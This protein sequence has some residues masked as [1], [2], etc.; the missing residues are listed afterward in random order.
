VTKPAPTETDGRQSLLKTLGSGVLTSIPVLSALVFIVVSLKVFRVSGMETTTTVA[1]VSKADT[2]ALLRGVIVTILP[3]FLE[4]LTA[5]TLWAWGAALPSRAQN[6]QAD[7]RAALY[8]PEAAAAWIMTVIMFFTIA[9]PVFLLFFAPVALT[10]FA[11]SRAIRHPEAVPW[12]LRLRKTLLVV[13]LCV[14]T[15]S[16]GL[17]TLASNPW[18][19]LQ[20][21]TVAPNHILT[22]NNRQLP[23]TFAAYVLN[24]DSQTVTLLLDQPRAVIEVTRG[25]ITPDMPFCVPHETGRWF[26]IR[27]TQVLG[28]DADVPSPYEVC[29]RSPP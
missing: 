25:E 11:L 10:T 17:L 18:L 26:K 5:V 3:G 23:G 6:V 22:L 27:A 7:A 1:I 12:V 14:G 2:F 29:P 8:S 15:V 19:P 4:A 21:I 28:I 24:H 16:L 9:W 13:A 20:K